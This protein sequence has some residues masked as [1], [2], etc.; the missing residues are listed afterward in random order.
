MNEKCGVGLCCDRSRVCWFKM[1]VWVI[2]NPALK[3]LFF[4]LHSIGGKKMNDLPTLKNGE[5]L[6]KIIEFF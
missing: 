6:H 2:T 4:G 1:E 5:I 3:D